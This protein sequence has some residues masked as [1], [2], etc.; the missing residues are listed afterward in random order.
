M[1]FTFSYLDGA[2][3]EDAYGKIRCHHIKAPTT[4]E[5]GVLGNRISRRVA[6][7]L[8]RR[9]FLERDEDNSYLTLETSEDEAMQQ[10]YG[11]SIT[12]ATAPALLY[13]RDAGPL[14]PRACIHAVVPHRHRTPTRPQGIHLAEP[15]AGSGAEG[16]FEPGCQ[17][18]RFQL[19]CRGDGR[20]TPA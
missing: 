18:G 7:F 14:L 6:K 16:G 15:A 12:S 3:A 9:G 2:Y 13:L 17:R 4:E 1:K 20:S 19:A 5:L 8:E 10:L 11:H